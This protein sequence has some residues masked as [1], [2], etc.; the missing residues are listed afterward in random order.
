[1]WIRTAGRVA[2]G[3]NIVLG[4]PERLR[5]FWEALNLKHEIAELRTRL[6]WIMK[7]VVSMAKIAVQ[8]RRTHFN[9]S[10]DPRVWQVLELLDVK[11][12]ISEELE[13]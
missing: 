3:H 9:L 5:H 4:R 8:G 12:V 10:K 7:E 11:R 6:R 1:M 13:C 2:A